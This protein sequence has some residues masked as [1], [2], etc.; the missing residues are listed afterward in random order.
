MRAD[1]RLVF[2]PKSWAAEFSR[3]VLWNLRL[4][5]ESAE[6]YYAGYLESGCDDP[7]RWISGEAALS[8]RHRYKTLRLGAYERLDAFF[9]EVSER[10]V[11]PSG[12]TDIEV[13][14]RIDEEGL[15]RQ[16]RE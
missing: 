15:D 8:K 11:W 12:E 4:A 5:L 6:S 13:A 9:E 14:W 7:L 1:V 2:Q 3:S 10:L 16:D